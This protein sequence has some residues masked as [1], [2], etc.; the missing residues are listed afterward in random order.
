[1]IRLT[2]GILIGAIGSGYY[3]DSETTKTLVMD[4]IEQANILLDWLSVKID[5]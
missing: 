2:I 4:G 5:S 3:F 1:M